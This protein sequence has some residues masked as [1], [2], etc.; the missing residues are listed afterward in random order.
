MNDKNFMMVLSVVFNVFG[1]V[2]D[3][4]WIILLAPF[5]MRKPTGDKI[6]A[7][8]LAAWIML[9]LMRGFL[10]FNPEPRTSMFLYEPLNTFLF[11]VVGVGL[12]AFF[13]LMQ[14]RQRQ[15]FEK[16]TAAVQAIEDLLRLSPSEFEDMVVQL[17]R[18]AGHGAQK[19][20]AVGDNGIDVVVQAKNGEKWVVQCKRWKGSVGEPLVRDFYGAMQHAKADKG[21]MI[22]VGKFTRPA[23]LWAKGKPIT[24]YDGEQFLAAWQKV[25]AQAAI[26]SS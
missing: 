7:G 17:Y 22:A 9:A 19:T 18:M 25:Q 20:G 4:W 16:K 2:F 10:I 24:L 6:L 14:R 15:Q 23:Q 21:T 12:F 11:F 8:M 5:R 26:T 13:S 3:L 1:I